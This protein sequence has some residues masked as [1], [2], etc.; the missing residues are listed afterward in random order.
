MYIYIYI[1]IYKYIDIY[2]YIYRWLP[3]KAYPLREDAHKQTQAPHTKTAPHTNTCTAH[4]SMH[5]TLT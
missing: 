1:Y 4:E 2:M 3:T 5:H